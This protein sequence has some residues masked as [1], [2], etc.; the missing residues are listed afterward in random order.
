ML[1][2]HATLAQKPRAGNVKRD[3]T[4]EAAM[5]RSAI[6]L[7]A[8]VL[9][10][11]GARDVRSRA[12]VLV[13]LVACLAISQIPLASVAA[14]HVKWFATCTPSDSPIPLQ[15]VL[16]GRFWLLLALF[17][18][19]FYVS[20]KA[21]LTAFGT[22]L[23]T[24]LDRA[25]SFLRERTDVL[26][27]A[28]AAVSFALLWADGTVV[29]TPE[30]KGNSVS[31]SAIQ[32][33]IPIYLAARATLPAAAAGILVLYG[34]GVATYGLFH[35]LDYPI[36]LGLAVYFALSVTDN[37]KAHAF[38]LSCLR[39][40]VA[41][42]L[43]WPA[44]EKFL[45]PGWIVP[46]ALAHPELTLGFDLDTVTTAAGVVEFGLAFAL[47]WTPMIR[48]LGALALAL[49]L[50]AATFDFGK[51]DGIG[52]LMII[53]VLLAVVAEPGAE[54]ARCRPALA[55]IASGTALLAAIFLYSG[56]HTLYYGPWHA[57]LVPIMSGTTLLAVI[58]LYLS[59]G[60]HA[61]VRAARRSPRRTRLAR[62]TAGDAVLQLHPR[63]F[64]APLRG[65]RTS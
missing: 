35:M 36:Y 47:F 17:I 23:N 62:D 11:G 30:L 8:N 55:P 25:T 49:L 58:S 7:R 13:V 48:R 16:T 5:G 3:A 60:V 43:L 27:R 59:G 46:I 32:A 18:L 51:I 44:M 57:A 24:L 52:H 54:N 12:L 42:S 38:R 19:L 61:L 33:L 53:A 26:L 21:E 2:A 56:V 34:Y 37:S 65:L 45:Y 28:V 22:F 64:A 4:I 14:A 1:A 41:L 20:C 10:R 39:W 31:L 15:T 40:T 9:M 50:F 6:G 63:S 29:L